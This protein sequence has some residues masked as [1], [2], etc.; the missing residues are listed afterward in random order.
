MQAK[1]IQAE[2]HPQAAHFAIP[3]LQDLAGSLSFLVVLIHGAFGSKNG[4]FAED[5]VSSFQTGF[6]CT[7]RA[8]SC[9]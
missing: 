1:Q 8:A 3:D 7:P 2:K 6:L 4:I 9:A 5:I